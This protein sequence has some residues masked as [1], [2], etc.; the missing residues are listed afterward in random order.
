LRLNV[1]GVLDINKGV[2]GV[3]DG[4]FLVI[5]RKVDDKLGRLELLVRERIL[6][7]R[8]ALVAPDSVSASYDTATDDDK[9]YN[10]LT[11]NNEDQFDDDTPAYTVV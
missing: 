6:I 7:G 4:L 5:Q 8:Q 1:P 9:Q 2:I 10:Y 11:E 3:V